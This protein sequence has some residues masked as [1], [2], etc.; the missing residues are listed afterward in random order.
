MSRL[1]YQTSEKHDSSWFDSI[2]TLRVKGQDRKENIDSRDNSI[3]VRMILSTL[4]YA[5]FYKLHI[6]FFPEGSRVFTKK[7]FSKFHEIYLAALIMS[8]GYILFQ[9]I[10]LQECIITIY[11]HHDSI[12]K[13]ISRNQDQHFI[14]H[15]IVHVKSQIFYKIV[16]VN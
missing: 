15:I 11:F 1:L 4:T 16:L 3:S 6:L 12:L 2:L 7:M 13:L 9:I 10:V 14:Y 5:Y 8:S